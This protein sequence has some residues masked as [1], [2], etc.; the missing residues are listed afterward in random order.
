MESNRPKRA[1]SLDL[2]WSTK[3]QP[4]HLAAD[5]ETVSAAERAIALSRD[6]LLAAQQPDG[7]W[8]AEL[9]GDTILESEYILLLAF[10]GEHASETARKA[11]RYLLHAQRNDG[12]WSTYPGGPVDTSGSVK[13]YFA[14]KLTGHDPESEPMRRARAAI[15]AHGGADAVNSF[16]RYY[17]ALL[18]QISY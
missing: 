2:A 10:L 6:W 3:V 16:T 13:A 5:S 4:D 18:G 8:V 17:L 1:L 12:G 9:E 15:L 11:A 14:L 7:H